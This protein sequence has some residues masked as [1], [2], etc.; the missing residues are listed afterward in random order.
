MFMD[1]RERRIRPLV[2]A[3]VLV[4]TIL[5]SPIGVPVYFV[6]RALLRRDA[7]AGPSTDAEPA[8]AAVRGA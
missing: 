7:G 4:L 2:M 5:L 6:V 3:P 8:G 1:S